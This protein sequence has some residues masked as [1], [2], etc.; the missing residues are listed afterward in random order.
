MMKA[1][2]IGTIVSV[3][4]FLF[5]LQGVRVIFSVLFGIIYDQIFEGPIDSWLVIS[6]LFVVLA[7]AAP[8]WT[9]G[10]N[11]NRWAWV[12]ASITALAR[13]SLSVNLADVRFWGSLFTVAFGSLYLT[14]RLQ[15]DRRSFVQCML[16]ALVLDQ[17]LRV[18]GDTY[19][20]SLRS[21][22][23]YVQV[24]WSI[25][26]IAF[27]WLVL[28]RSDE[29]YVEPL[30]IRFVDGIALSG[31]LFLQISLLSFPNAAARW[32]STA[33]FISAALMMGLSIL[34][35]L[36]AVRDIFERVFQT[37]MA[38][39]G[40]SMLLLLGLV[41]GYF[42]EGGLSLLAI[43]AAQVATLCAF[44]A[45]FENV[46]KT[47]RITGGAIAS[48]MVLFLV[49]NF[50]YAFTFTYAYTLPVLRGYGWAVF[51]A[52]GVMVGVGVVFQL[53]AESR[54]PPPRLCLVP[55][56]MFALLALAVAL[57]VAWP[58]PAASF[59]AEG[60]VRAATYNIHYGYDD[61]WH[62]TLEDMAR[63]IEEAEVDVV[64][65]QEVDTARITSYCVDDAY[66]LARRLQMNQVY[67]PTVEHLTGIA[68]LY[69]GPVAPSTQKLLTSLQE[70]TGIIEVNLEFDAAL[71]NAYAVWMG[72][73]DED[74][75]TQ[76]TQALEFVGDHSS[77]IFG[78]DFNA[79]IHESVPQAVLAA[80]FEDPFIVLG[81]D[82]PPFTSPAIEPQ[83]RIDFVWLRDLKPLAAAVSTSLASDHR[84]VVVEIEMP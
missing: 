39:L 70:Q 58:K 78:G 56:G 41:V 76:I 82:P 27:A 55:E 16:S 69:R 15:L 64:M 38:G 18:M 45:T 5:L 37:S 48:G 43:L 35:V 23:L 46:P 36:P 71:L 28:R 40:L 79:E 74:T 81:I 34:F 61:Y 68:L 26:V 19:D 54:I 25:A 60:V 73:S 1:R 72:L 4:V 22:W 30:G 31:F 12:F 66:Y 8:L 24:V 50:V 6:N 10:K 47:T 33:Y 21:S 84:M 17:V 13:V 63:T 3:S 49:L 57:V 29:E 77:A 9:P 51:L 14:T 59:H 67:L 11:R 62:F 53:P 2:G 75:Q 83:T 44:A 7:F 80:G 20:P 65:L 42:S 52:A 32:S